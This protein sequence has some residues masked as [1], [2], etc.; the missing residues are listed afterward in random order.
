MS[1]IYRFMMSLFIVFSCILIISFKGVNS[2]KPGKA[3]NN[4]IAIEVT[5]S[6]PIL[7]E[8]YYRVYYIDNWIINHSRYQFDSSETQLQ[9]DSNS[10]QLSG[11]MDLLLSEKRDMFFVFHKDSSFGYNY[12]ANWEMKNNIRLSVDSVLKERTLQPGNLNSILNLKADSISWSDDRSELKEVYIFQPTKEI[13]TIRRILY[14]SKELKHIK[15]TFLKEIDLAKKMKLYKI[16]GY[17]EQHY[18]EKEKRLWPT[19]KSRS[20]MKQIPI[21]NLS[22]IMEYID[23]YKKSSGQ[24]F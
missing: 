1:I 8:D 12:D 4:I 15:E 20:E 13:P 10:N 17:S 16:E 18:S 24:G 7:G 23:K 9:I 21:N 19:M 6:D 2:C 5:I 14:Y 11:K 3:N 22:Q